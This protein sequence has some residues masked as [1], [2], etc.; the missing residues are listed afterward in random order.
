MNKYCTVL[1]VLVG[2]YSQRHRIISQLFYYLLQR[3]YYNRYSTLSTELSVDVL[4]PSRLTSNSLRL[5]SLE[6]SFE[7]LT[8]V[9][10]GGWLGTDLSLA[11]AKSG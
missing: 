3:R 9:H 4:S 7:L 11:A 5:F 8:S 10:L 2:V 6:A 1:A